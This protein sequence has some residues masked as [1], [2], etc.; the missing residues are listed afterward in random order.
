MAQVTVDLGNVMGPTGPVGP[1]G[2]TGPTGPKGATGEAGQ[3]PDILDVFPVG[4]VF[5][6]KQSAGTFNPAEQF[7]GS[8][9]LDQ[10]TYLFTG[11]KR[12][13]RTA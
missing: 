4:S 8:W 11:I 7:G 13:W 3:N 12:Y 10:D 5:E 6:V 2:P 9:T 1:T